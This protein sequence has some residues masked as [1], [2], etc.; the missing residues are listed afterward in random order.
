MKTIYHSLRFA[1]DLDE[2]NETVKGLLALPNEEQVKLLEGMLK[3]LLVPTIMPAI[4]ELNA[5]NS[6]AT[7]RF[8]K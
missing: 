7:L 1:T 3:S 2:N 6:Y 8:V 4:D 5:G